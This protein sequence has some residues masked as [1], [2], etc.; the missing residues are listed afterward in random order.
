VRLVHET[1]DLISEIPLAVGGETGIVLPEVHLGAAARD[2]PWGQPRLAVSDPALPWSKRAVDL[3]LTM[4]L[5]LAGSVVLVPLLA[6]I[7]LLIK[8]TSAG[9]VLHRQRR[10][11]KGGRSFLMWKFRTMVA[12]ADRVL[13]EVLARDEGLRAEWERDHKLRHDP[14]ITSVGRFLRRTSLDELPQIWNVLQG[15]MSLVGPRPIFSTDI[16][17][18]GASFRHY[19]RVL[20]G[21]TGLWQTSGRNR[22]SHPQ[23]VRLDAYYVKHWSL[24]LDLR[25]LSR[26][27]RVV[28]RCD[29][30]Y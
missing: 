20:P 30:A 5:I 25:I 3:T 16:D 4:A 28:L 12:D 21:I 9:P 18:Y 2:E 29:G 14:R 1:Q 7:A 11:G 22:L 8:L 10:I 27:P 26:T 13:D 23:R 17:K 19:T 15:E 24:W 6:S